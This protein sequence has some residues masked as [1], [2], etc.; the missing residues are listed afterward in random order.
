MDLDKLI[1]RAYNNAKNKGF[2]QDYDLI[3]RLLEEEAVNEEEYKLLYN[4]MLSKY[5]AL[6]T[7]ELGEAV[8]G[9]RKGRALYGKDNF[10]EEL[11]DSVIRIFDLGGMAEELFNVPGRLAEELMVKMKINESREFKHG[12]EF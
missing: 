3:N 6:I 9:L 5:I 1:Q 2:H 11:A 10:F 12:K 7:S 4:G 8:E